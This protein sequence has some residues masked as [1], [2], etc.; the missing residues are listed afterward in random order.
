MTFEEILDQAIAMLQ[1]RGR[2]TYSTLKRQFQLDDAALDDLKNELIAGQRLA[3]DEQGNVLVWIGAAGPMSPAPSPSATTQEYAPLTYTPSYLA[4]KILS[5]RSALEGERKLVTVLF[6]D[7]K[8]SM[9]LLADRDPEEARQLLDPVLERMM[10]AVHRYEGTVNQ[11]MGDGIMALFGAPIAHEDHA[12]RACYAALAMQEAVKHY[13]AEV[14]RTHGVPL[15]MRVGMNAGEVVVRAIGNDLHMDYSAIGQTTHLAARMEQMAMPGSI[16]ITQAVRSLAEGYVQVNP[17]GPVPVKGLTEPVVVFALV[18]ARGIQR[19]FQATA[20]RG[21]TQFVGRETELAALLQAVERAAT[22]AG[23]VVA[24]VGEAGVGKSRLVYEL[25]H[26]PQTQ[27]WRLLESAAVSYGQAVPYVPVID[28][29]RRY[30]TVEERDDP[31]VIRTKVTERVLALD[32]TLQDTLPALLVLL[33]AL[34]EDHPFLQL[35]PPQRRQRTLEALTRVLLRESRIQPFVLVCEDLHWIDTETQALLDRL[36]ESLPTAPLLLLVTYRPEYQHGWGSHTSY[37]QLRLDPLSAVSADAL[38]QALVGDDRGLTSLKQL[39]ITRTAGNPFFLEESV[40]TLVETGMVVGT[41]GAYRLTQDVTTIQVPATVQAMLAARIDRLAADEKQLLQTAAVLGTEVPVPLLQAIAEGPADVLQRGLTHLQA[42][43]FLDETRL[44]PERTF[45]FMHALTHEVAYSSLL[46]TRRQALHLAAGRALERLYADRLEDVDERLAYHYA[47]TTE[48]DKA[49]EYLTRFARKAARGYALVEA[50]TALQEALRHVEH[51]P[52]E[53]RDRR[54]LD[55]VMRQARAFTALGRLPET[56]DLLIREQACVERLQEPR[57]VGSYHFRLGHTAGLVGDHARA[58]QHGQRALTVAT[59]CGDTATMSRAYFLLSMEG[60]WTDQCL[61]GVTYGQQAITLLE[62]TGD[63]GWL[64]LA[65]CAVGF[66]YAGL[67]ELERALAAST[68][69]LAIGDALRDA[70]LQSMAAG[71]SA[72][73]YALQGAW[74]AG[75]EAGQRALEQ[76]RD[77]YRT[78]ASMAYLSYAYLEKGDSAAA[79]PLLEQAAEHQHQFRMLHHV[80]WAI[81]WLGEAYSLQGQRVRA[82]DLALQGLAMAKEIGFGLGIGW[83]QR[84]LGRIALANGA[85][86]EAATTLQEALQTFTAMHARAEVART[87][88]DLAALAQ[89]Q[90]AP[91]RTARHLHDAYGLFWELRVPIYVERARHLAAAFGVS[92]PETKEV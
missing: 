18:D 70:R 15:Q 45:T 79:I 3:V 59:Q 1:R 72:W 78:A 89:T 47:K 87:S 10:A 33:D 63:Q 26:V 12:V 43:G 23:Q 76:A 69:A 50:V 38:L 90:G 20:V 13:A 36:V 75:I 64:G 68:R 14:Q 16:L 39:L 24:L 35:D 58:A 80:S 53:A 37:T 6:A 82:R 88:L 73:A 22:G 31:R 51:V 52:G 29:L 32:E 62:Q 40:R 7:L 27:G 46:T 67:G 19:R 74:Q 91:E 5:S 92:L 49:V 28:L 8:G 81:T 85:L 17:L 84:A 83:A 57:L 56:L 86:A 41:P 54:R 48:A 34:P 25:L 65:Y 30:S 55:L 77:P 61:Q 21:L 60:V 11:V 9:E 71:V 2:L 44:F 42:A 66:N 4:E